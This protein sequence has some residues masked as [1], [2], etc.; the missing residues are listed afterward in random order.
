V[1]LSVDE[2]DCHWFDPAGNRIPS[3]LE[4]ALT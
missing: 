3:S 4:V 1:S 2:R